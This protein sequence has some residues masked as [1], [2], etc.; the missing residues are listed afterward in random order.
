MKARPTVRFS[1]V[2]V[3]IAAAACAET[4][5]VA[6]TASETAKQDYLAGM[7][8]M[9]AG[10]YTRALQLMSQ[11]VR[12]PSPQYAPLARLRIG[13]A[14]FLQERF[15]EAIES[16]RTFIAQHGSD[17]NLPYARYRIAAAYYERMPSDWFA[18]PPAYEMDQSM[19]RQAARELEGFLDTFP[20]SRFADD[21]RRMLGTARRM[22]VD[23]ELY[24]ARYYAREEKW[25]AVAWRL[26]GAVRE[27]PDLAR[28]PD[29]VWRLAGAWRD[30]GDVAEAVRAYALY[31]ESFPD[32]PRRE[33]A[34]AELARIRKEV[35]IAP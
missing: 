33:D 3:S 19:T 17:P 35:E 16:Y 8:E 28:T 6:P 9:V 29:I 23:H 12:S 2:A 24:V 4:A 14:L 21:A 25:R 34:K 26:D 18:A 30:A 20:T 32:G 31:L 7:E 13:D 11:V 5:A 27:F 15:E 1:L 10:N 22:L